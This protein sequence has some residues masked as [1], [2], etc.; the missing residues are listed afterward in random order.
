ME[1]WKTRE[2]S[3]SWNH[4]T[5][6]SGGKTT[7]IFTRA[8]RYFESYTCR[9]FNVRIKFNCYVMINVLKIQTTTTIFL[10]FIKCIL[11]FI[12]SRPS[13]KSPIPLNRYDDVLDNSTQQRS[14]SR[15]PEPKL[16]ARAVYNFVGLTSKYEIWLPNYI[17]KFDYSRFIVENL[18]EYNPVFLLNREL[19]FRKGDIIFV[20]R[21]VDKN[22]YEGEHN[23]MIGLFPLN[24]VEVPSHSWDLCIAH[25][26]VISNL[27]VCFS[28]SRR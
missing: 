11:P 4:K 10:K 5:N 12:I 26:P 14:R 24:Y 18:V 13:Q 3:T 7:K 6:L 23:A 25:F 8:A 19:T 9:Y 17:F 20:K 16:V 21:R 2:P 28:P 22:W 15:T 1:R 27:F